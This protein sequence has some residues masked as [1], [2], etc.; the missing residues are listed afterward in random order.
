MSI[1]H[2]T[3]RPSKQS[4]IGERYTLSAGILNSVMS[5][6]HLVLGVSAW[7]FRFTRLGI[8]RLISPT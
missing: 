5:V 8:S 4:V 7:E 1:E 2:V 3:T 6:S